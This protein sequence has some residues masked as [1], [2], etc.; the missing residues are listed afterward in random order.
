MLEDTILH[1]AVC[2]TEPDPFPLCSDRRCSRIGSFAIGTY[3]VERGL[4]SFVQLCVSPNEIFVRTDSSIN[5]RSVIVA[6]RLLCISHHGGTSNS[7][8]KQL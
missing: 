7:D 6:N 2:V 5:A 8:A 4:V 1:Q 3:N